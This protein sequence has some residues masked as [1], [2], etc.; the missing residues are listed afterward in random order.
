MQSSCN[1]IS[2]GANG[3]DELGG[4]A[5]QYSDVSELCVDHLAILG[6]C[7]AAVCALGVLLYVD[8][9]AI[10]VTA[11]QRFSVVLPTKYL[12]ICFAC[13]W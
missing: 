3:S 2:K 13:C 11:R 7:T 9:L 12:C 8:Y 6:Y 5:S 4:N 1:G 10:W